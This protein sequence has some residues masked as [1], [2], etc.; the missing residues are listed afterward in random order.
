MRKGHQKKHFMDILTGIVFLMVLDKSYVDRFYHFYLGS[1][2]KVDPKVSCLQK[3]FEMIFMY[4][5]Q[6]YKW[7]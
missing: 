6:G 7:G 1:I 3:Y 5:N 4:V 2:S